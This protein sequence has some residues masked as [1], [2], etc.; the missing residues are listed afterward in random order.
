MRR[1]RPILLR[2]KVIRHSDVLPVPGSKYFNST[3]ECWTRSSFAAVERRHS[4][5]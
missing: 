1:V 4:E 3:G 5:T 2:P